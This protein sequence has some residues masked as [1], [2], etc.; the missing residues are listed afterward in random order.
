[1]KR[2]IHKHL[3]KYIFHNHV[4]HI[5]L[6][7]IFGIGVIVNMFGS[8]AQQ[9][10]IFF[11]FNSFI[12]QYN[13]TT[14]INFQYG[15]NSLTWIIARSWRTTLS[16]PETISL[17]W[18]TI[19]CTK[20]LQWMY[21]NPIRWAK[22]WPLDETT[23]QKLKEIDWSYNSMLVEGGIYTNCSGA[24][25]QNHFVI[26][27]ITHNQLGLQY[28]LFAG[29]R[30]SAVENILNGV[31]DLNWWTLVF[32]NNYF[33]GRLFDKYW[34]WLGDISSQNLPGQILL[35]WFTWAVFFPWISNIVNANLKTLYQSSIFSIAWLSSPTMLSLS[36]GILY[37]NNTLVGSQSVVNNG[38][39]L[40]IELFSSTEYDTIVKSIITVGSLTGEFTIRT[41]PKQPDVC[42]LT[43]E[44][45]ASI[46]SVFSGLVAEYW[47]TTKM[48]TLLVTMKSM[49]KDMQDF[50]YDCN[51]AYLESLAEKYVK[52]K[53][54]ESDSVH[55]APNCKKYPIIYEKDKGYTSPVFKIRQYFATR[56]NIMMFIDS[57]N[58]WDCN[59]S[60]YDR[61]QDTADIGENMFVAPNG[62][63]YE[64]V[65]SG[66]EFY[67]P[68]MNTKKVFTT[69]DWLT[70]FISKW[71]P[72][73]EVW[74]H[75]VDTTRTPVVYAAS[76]SKEYK[77]YKTD[78]WFMSYKLVKIQYFSTQQEII[79][80]IE[81]YNKR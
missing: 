41:K 24:W 79:S 77:I 4:F 50:N 30:Y 3:K 59:V 42:S 19:A 10:T 80:Y 12:S 35:G 40:K 68:T 32:Q 39:N 78:K 54:L 16:T 7:L 55:I 26:G 23:L 71:N 46:E 53:D 2:N 51:L 8:N 43:Q 47:T 25:I 1:M 74:D 34:W 70:N 48:T 20:Q 73:I 21:Y 69:K 44:E 75:K 28:S 62:K 33:Q 37:L 64:I 81:K 67:S 14:S 76:N 5:A 57:K 52:D 31:Q 66:W 36:T 13:N 22:L 17:S 61:S 29:L 60:V 65:E 9:S 45:K 15:G 56:T 58:P 6:G 27:Q 63:V 72:A 18:T 49:I 11:P 38:D